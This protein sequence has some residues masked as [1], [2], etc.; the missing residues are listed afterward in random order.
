MCSF[1][2]FLKNN[3]IP[4]FLC[5]FIPG[6]ATI[7][8]GIVYL[9][10]ATLV[11]ETDTLHL[12]AIHWQYLFKQRLKLKKPSCFNTK[13]LIGSILART[14]IENYRCTYYFSL[15]K[16]VSCC[17]TIPLHRHNS[18]ENSLK[19]HDISTK[20]MGSSDMQHKLV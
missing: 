3:M 1:S 16:I 15:D 18:I 13:S 20:Q 4:K 2:L 11:K 5:L 7:D 10:G 17:D 6:C 8:W 12:E 14:C 19:A 9:L